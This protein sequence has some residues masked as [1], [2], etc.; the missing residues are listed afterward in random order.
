MANI[1]TYR[2]RKTP[3]EKARILNA[4]ERSG[5]PRKEFA[6]QHGLHVSTLQRWLRTRAPDPAPA[7]GPLIEL[8]NL[9]GTRPAG[10]T[11]RVCLPRGLALEVT[12]GFQPGEVQSLVQLLQ[13]L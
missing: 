8:P 4:Y 6:R 11:Y 7:S 13:G 12:P 2:Y 9:L 10:P 1:L 5:L 3:A